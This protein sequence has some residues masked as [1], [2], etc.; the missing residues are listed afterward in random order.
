VALLNDHG[1]DAQTMLQKK[2]GGKSLTR[3]FHRKACV[4][5]ISDGYAK[6]ATGDRAEFTRVRNLDRRTFI[7][8]VSRTM[9]AK[10]VRCGPTKNSSSD[11][12]REAM[13]L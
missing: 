9:A 5:F 3:R 11:I 8:D 1:S 4:F 10:R 12:T 2:T 6:A 7:W 13:G